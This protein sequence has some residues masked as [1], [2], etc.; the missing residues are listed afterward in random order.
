MSDGRLDDV[1]VVILDEVHYLADASR[2]TVWEETIIYCPPAVQL[3]CLS[4]TVGNPDD[5]AGWIE[6]ALSR[7]RTVSHG[8]DRLP[9]RAA[10]MALQHAPRPNVARDGTAPQQTRR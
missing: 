3:L 2:G 4:A 1:G 7:R 6:S 10:A 8:G 9:P 5:L